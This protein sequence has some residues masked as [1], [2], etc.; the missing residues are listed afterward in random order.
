M[1]RNKAQ[2]QALVSADH[3][4]NRMIQQLSDPEVFFLLH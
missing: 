2:I 3:V 1:R 4:T